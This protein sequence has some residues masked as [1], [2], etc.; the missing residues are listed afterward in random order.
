[1]LGIT[2]GNV[3]RNEVSAQNA[4]GGAGFF[5][6]SNHGRLT[7]SD[8]AAHGAYKIT[9]ENARLGIFAHDGEWLALQRGGY[10]L[11]FDRHDLV[12]DVSHEF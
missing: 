9:R 5:D 6:F 2:L 1:M 8:L 7:P 12:E 4:F 3:G 11:A 10:F